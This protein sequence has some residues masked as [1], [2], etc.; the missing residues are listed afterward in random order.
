MQA[1]MSLITSF[2]VVKGKGGREGAG[3]KGAMWDEAERHWV[4]AG[5]G[6][7]RAGHESSMAE[8]T[9]DRQ[10]LWGGKDTWGWMDREEQVALQV[11]RTEVTW[12]RSGVFHASWGGR[13]GPLLPATRQYLY[14]SEHQSQFCRGA[15]GEGR[16]M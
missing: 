7:D 6:Q 13:V 11:P 8:W 10:T 4:S 16:V 5:V 15:E 3:V 1:Q 14:C 2:I 9:V 12:G